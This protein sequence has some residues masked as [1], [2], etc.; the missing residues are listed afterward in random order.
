MDARASDAAA[1]HA[2]RVALV[3]GGAGAIAAAICRR[4]AAD[5]ADVVVAGAGWA[6]SPT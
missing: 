4:L 1:E 3:T 5:G 6:S 2:G